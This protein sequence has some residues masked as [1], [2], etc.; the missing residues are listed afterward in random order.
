M[1]SRSTIQKLQCMVRANVFVS[2]QLLLWTIRDFVVSLQLAI[3]IRLIKAAKKAAFIVYYFFYMGD[4]FFRNFSLVYEMTAKV[5]FYHEI[6]KCF[7][8]K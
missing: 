2:S 1:G 8:M 7:T 5:C 3:K 6:Y 4:C